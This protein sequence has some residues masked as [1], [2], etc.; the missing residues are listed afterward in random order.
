LVAKRLPLRPAVLG[1][2]AVGLELGQAYLRLGS[3][4]TVIEHSLL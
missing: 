3:R 4:V 2:S 1:G